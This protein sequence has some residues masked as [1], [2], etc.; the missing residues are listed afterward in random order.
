VIVC[1]LDLKGQI[2]AEGVGGL[3]ANR[4]NEE[5]TGI[6][7][8]FLLKSIPVGACRDV[9]RREIIRVALITRQGYTKLSKLDQASRCCKLAMTSADRLPGSFGTGHEEGICSMICRVCLLK[10]KWS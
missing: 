2:E 4:T 5:H 8:S 9:N 1:G 10:I 3:M 7:T 6:Y